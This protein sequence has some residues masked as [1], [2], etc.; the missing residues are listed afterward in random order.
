MEAGK[1]NHFSTLQEIV[2][3]LDFK[4]PRSS[5]GFQLRSAAAACNQ[6]SQ[7]ITSS[8]LSSG[9]SW[10]TPSS[11]WIQARERRPGRHHLLCRWITMSAL[12]AVSHRVNHSPVPCLT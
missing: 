3:L 7:A 8:I 9:N 2:G 5:S 6:L 11:R 12:V 1:S 10:S 4:L